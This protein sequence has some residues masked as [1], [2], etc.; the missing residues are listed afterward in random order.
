LVEIPAWAWAVV[1]LA[2]MPIVLLAFGVLFGFALLPSMLWDWL[3]GKKSNDD[4][5]GLYY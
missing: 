3:S 5:D 2:A 4:G 1:G